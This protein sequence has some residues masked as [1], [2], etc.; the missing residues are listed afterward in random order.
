[1]VVDAD[2]VGSAVEQND[3]FAVEDAER[4]VPVADAEERV[5]EALPGDPVL[6]DGVPP[7]APPTN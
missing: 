7:C 4:A 2:L 1:V 3:R 6:R 5:G